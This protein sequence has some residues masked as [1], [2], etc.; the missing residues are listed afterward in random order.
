M[1]PKPD[2]EKSEADESPVATWHRRLQGNRGDRAAL[3][4]AQTIEEAYG[5]VAFHQLY[6][7]LGKQIPDPVVARIAI[8]LA[9]IDADVKADTEPGHGMPAGAALGQALA[10]PRNGKPCLSEA[11]LRLLASAEDPDQFLRLLRGALALLDRTAPL[12]DVAR[13][14]RRWHAPESRPRVRRQLFLSYFQTALADAPET[15]HA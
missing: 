11:R 6:A 9:E 3:R 5:I 14:V 13:V 8:A 15:D 12:D 4:R 10:M 1:N 7:W 2:Q